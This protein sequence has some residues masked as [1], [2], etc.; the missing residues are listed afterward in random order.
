MATKSP[1]KSLPRAIEIVLALVGLGVTLPALLV[2]AVLI[3]ASS[4]GPVLFRQLRVGKNGV[5]FTLFKFRTMEIARSGPMVTSADDAR[6]TAIGKKLRRFKIDELPELWNVLRGDMS[7]VGPRPEVQEFVNLADPMWQIILEHRPGITD[8][9]TLRF[10]NEEQLLSKVVDKELYYK[11][12]VQPFKMRGYAKF[13]AGK[14]WKTDIRLI[15]RTLKAVVFPN[16][17][18]SPSA[19]EMKDLCNVNI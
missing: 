14:T 17:V 19:D 9:I 4:K 3:K 5:P 7:F 11:E 15:L 1:L 8:P 12:V 2:V 18:R 10:R 13:I 6:V 16:S